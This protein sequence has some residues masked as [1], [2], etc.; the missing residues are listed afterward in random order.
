M[1]L[2]FGLAALA[3]SLCSV[4]ALASDLTINVENLRNSNG[5]LF[6]GVVATESSDKEAFP[7]C[8]K[9]KSIRK[10]KLAM[11]NGKA[12]VTFYGLKDGEYA[13][14]MIHDENANGKLD[15]NFIGI[16]TEGI[17]VSNNSRLFGSP[18][19]DAAKFQIKGNTAITITTKYFM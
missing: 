15:T 16:P 8:D 17:G 5:Q 6:R 13:V 4:A 1:I 3:A 11:A 9:G 2:R 18:T 7:D 19:Y 12:S 10:Q 14:A